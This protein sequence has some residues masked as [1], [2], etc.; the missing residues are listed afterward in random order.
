MTVFFGYQYLREN[1]FFV[2]LLCTVN[3]FTD[4]FIIFEI[5]EP[6]PDWNVMVQSE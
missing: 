2:S 4:Y 5:K 1:G 6:F 3:N